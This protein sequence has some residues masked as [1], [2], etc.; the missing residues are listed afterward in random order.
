[1]AAQARSG[2]TALVLAAVVGLVWMH[3]LVASPPATAHSMQPS[4]F[5]AASERSHPAGDE[6]P[7]GGG[8]HGDLALAHVCLAVLAVGIGLLL[9]GLAARRTTADTQVVPPPRDGSLGHRLWWP[10][11]PDL[12]REL[13]V[14]RT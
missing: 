5:A 7:A 8:H 9:S 12:V 4:T 2:R 1:M 3:S 6:D 11:P 10:P 13:S 14:S